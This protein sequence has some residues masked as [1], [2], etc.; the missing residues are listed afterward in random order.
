MAFYIR[1]RRP[2]QNNDD[3][4]RVMGNKQEETIFTQALKGIQTQGVLYFITLVWSGLKSHVFCINVR[5]Q[6]YIYLQKPSLIY[7]TGAWTI[8]F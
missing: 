3:N 7:Y 8:Q 6:P 2:I 1:R 5:T 4:H